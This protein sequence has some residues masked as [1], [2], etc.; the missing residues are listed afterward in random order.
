[1]K[2]FL[3]WISYNR[4]LV[5]GLILGLIMAVILISCVAE[6]ASP[7]DPQKIVD[8]NGL[9]LEFSIWQAQNTITAK[10]F[11]FAMDDIKQQT[12][13]Q[14]QIEKAIITVAQNPT[15]AWQLF[16]DGTLLGV[17]FDNIR[18]RGLIAGL[19]RNKT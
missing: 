4:G 3:N 15:N 8:A 16:A 9:A 1:M 18:K 10:K 6:T 7:L 12:E 5:A 11:E 13:N 19:K 17:L 2:T 14:A